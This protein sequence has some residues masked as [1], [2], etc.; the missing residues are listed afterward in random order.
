MSLWQNNGHTKRFA[1]LSLKT[2]CIL[3]GKSDF[4]DMLELRSK[5]LRLSGINWVGQMYPQGGWQEC[6]RISESEKGICQCS[7]AGKGRKREVYM[8][9]D[10]KIYIVFE[11]GRKGCMSKI[12]IRSKKLAKGFSSFTFRRNMALLISCFY[13]HET[14]FRGIISR[15]IRSKFMLF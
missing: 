8:E 6:S 2:D 4:A 9:K 15:T 10:L 5:D 3:C 1:Y 14:H 11:D 13:L 12:I 7:R